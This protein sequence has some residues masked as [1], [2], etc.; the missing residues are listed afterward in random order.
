M[1]FVLLEEHISEADMPEVN[2]SNNDSCGG[3]GD[4][5]LP[6]AEEDFRIPIAASDPSQNKTG[7]K[8]TED[9]RCK[10]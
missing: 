6:Q 5:Q 2:M 4:E 3:N 9:D 10:W 7:T 1:S 8:M